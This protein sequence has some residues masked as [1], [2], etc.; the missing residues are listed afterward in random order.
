MEHD[1]GQV[2]QRALQGAGE[3]VLVGAVVHQERPRSRPH[4]SVCA[5]KSTKI[6]QIG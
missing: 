2:A 6:S 3:V 4:R 5:I 1:D